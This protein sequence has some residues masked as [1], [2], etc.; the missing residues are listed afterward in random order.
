MNYPTVD[1]Y[2]SELLLAI[3]KAQTVSWRL[4][5]AWTLVSDNG[6]VLICNGQLFNQ[7]NESLIN[8]LYTFSNAKKLFLSYCPLNNDLHLHA[9]LDALKLS[10][11]VELHI[12]T[13]GNDKKAVSELFAHTAIPAMVWPS[14]QT[15][16]AQTVGI[17]WVRSTH[18]PWVHVICSNSLGGGAFPLEQMS[19]QMGVIPYV[20]LKGIESSQLYVQSD[21]GNSVSTKLTMADP[22][23]VD[24]SRA[25][26][27][28]I[29]NLSVKAVSVVTVVCD[30]TWLALLIR[31]SLANEVSYFLSLRSSTSAIQPSIVE[32]P[33]NDQW[34][35]NS[36]EVMGDFMQVVLQKGLPTPLK[37]KANQGTSG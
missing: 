22:Q 30:S 6:E 35:I 37:H 19:E 11:L 12:F 15:Q 10:N 14:D 24:S 4:G 26:I 9:L 16:S 21:Q 28:Q 7:H 27:Q 25:M 23:F 36:S 13:L 33:E 17:A 18:R 29:N 5:V 2:P 32:F 31:M 20:T 8:D 34:T 1:T 3:N